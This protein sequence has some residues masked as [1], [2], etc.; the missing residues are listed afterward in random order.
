MPSLS[1]RGAFWLTVFSLLLLGWTQVIGIAFAQEISTTVDIPIWD[2]LRPYVIEIVSIIVAAAVAWASKKFHDLTGIEIEAKH[3]EA[4][5]SAL[6]N[7]ANLIMAKYPKGGVSFDT[8]N[9]Q[10]SVAIR[11]VLNSV[12]DAVEHFKLTPDFIGEMVKAKIP[13]VVATNEPKPPI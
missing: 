2:A 12:P 4:L 1:F 6:L 13:V 9:E 11:Y 8:Q 7:G 10:L 5:Q 3:R